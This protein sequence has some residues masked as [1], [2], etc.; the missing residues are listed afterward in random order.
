[1]TDWKVG[2]RCASSGEPTLGLGMIQKVGERNVHVVFPGTQ[3]ERVYA[4]D[5][6]PLRRVTFQPGETVTNLGGDR[7]VVEEVRE[8]KGL[9]FYFGETEMLPET[10]LDHGTVYSRPDQQLLAGHLFKPEEFDLRIA[11]W[12]HRHAALSSP[13]RG[14]VGPRVQLVEHQLFIA[15]Q[16]SYRHHPRVLLSDEVGLGKTIEAG[17]IFHRLWITGEI[18][19]VLVLVPGPLLHQ[20]LTEFYRKFNILFNIMTSQYAGELESIHP[21]LNPY[22]AHQCILQNLDELE[23]DSDLREH[24]IDSEWDLL[25]VDEAH[26]LHWSR[27]QASPNY[28]LIAKLSENCGGILLLTATPRQLGLESHFGRLKLL[29]PQ[30][31]DN[32]EAFSK[33]AGRYQA[34]AHMADEL[35]EGKFSQSKTKLLDLFPNDRGLQELIEQNP[36]PQNQAQK[37]IQA[38]LDRHGTGRMVFRNRRKVM[39]GFPKRTVQPVYLDTNPEYERFLDTL[40]DFSQ[41]EGTLKRVLAGPPALAANEFKSKTTLASLKK[42]WLADPRLQ[43]LIPFLRQHP[44]E[45]FLLIC[46]HK[47]IVL[48]LQDQLAHVKDL[49]VATFHE[50][51]SILERDR[52]AAYFSKPDGARILLC[53]EIGSEGRNFQFVHRL[54]LFDL[55]LNP[56]LLEQRIGRLDRIG[57]RQDIQIYVP[58]PKKGP[59]VPLFH[60][61]HDA[62]NAFVQPVLEGDYLFENLKTE[63]PSIFGMNDEDFQHFLQ[64]SVQIIEEVKQSLEEGRDKL[65]ERHS[66]DPEKGKSLAE[67]V[68]E[69]DSAPELKQFMDG[70]FELFGVNTEDQSEPPTQILKPSPHMKVSQFPCL[71]AEGLEITYDRELAIHREELAFLTLDHPMVSGTIDLMLNLDRGVTSFALWKQAPSPGI[72]VQSLWILESPGAGE[73]GLERYL[74]PTP[75]LFTID[76]DRQLRP[77]LQE[78][79]SQTRLEKGPLVTLH[80]QRQPLGDILTSLI[81]VSESKATRLAERQLRKAKQ[82]AIQAL[83]SELERLIALKAINTGIREEEIAAIREKR[84]QILELLKKSRARM[85]AVRMVLMVP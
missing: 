52:Q 79:I 59:M 84:E 5:K 58:L 26:H 2:Q 11:A 34:I 12:S 50:D 8:E 70:A 44:T 9:L 43:W 55:P 41:N 36:L 14:L 83:D 29:D 35:A 10:E 85:D 15:D 66:F 74:P 4:K 13:V 3:T 37:I 80:Q 16:V 31:F 60:W 23:E 78:A 64:H 20:W 33:E 69:V 22:S 76:Q 53:S 21:N 19:R 32:F 56:A 25:I 62:L 63:L 67:E 65:L 39:A 54:I 77:D 17:L 71:P 27:K 47:K 68:T 73:F 82:T 30:R 51:L 1:M 18:K 72:L 45:K 49:E 6:A 42:F 38:L 81:E 40:G 75:F 48:A 24:L 61:Y 57:Q 7:F 28:Q 46:S